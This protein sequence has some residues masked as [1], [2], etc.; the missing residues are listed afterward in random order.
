MLPGIASASSVIAPPSG[1]DW[2]LYVYGNARV[3]Y[4]VINSVTGL[5]APDFGHSGYQT[6]MLL[7]ATLGF[8]SLAIAAGFD[9]SKNFMK[10]FTYIFVV[11]M[12]SLSTT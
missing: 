11:W 7:L 2:D 6:L 5:I 10:M 4:D 8:L 9:P 1:S 3:V 12:I